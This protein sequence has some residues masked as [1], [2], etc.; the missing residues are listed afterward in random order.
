VVYS[1]PREYPVINH[2]LQFR[3]ERRCF[4]NLKSLNGAPELKLVADESNEE[5]YYTLDGMTSSRRKT[6]DGFIPTANCRRS[7]SERPMRQG[8]DEIFRCIVGWTGESKKHC[9]K[10]EIEELAATMMSTVYDVKFFSKFCKNK[11]KRCYRS[12]RDRH[13]G[14]LLLSQRFILTSP[15]A[16]WW[17][18]NQC[19][20]L[21]K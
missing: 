17:K 6:N 21:R 2:K 3:A 16:M 14:L 7:N 19:P 15:K 13:T 11:I 8:K 18:E 9:S 1:L 4:I 12:I 20:L 10:K 5:Q